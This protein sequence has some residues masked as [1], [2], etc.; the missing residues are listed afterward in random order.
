[1]TL[2]LTWFPMWLRPTCEVLLI[3]ELA[4]GSERKY[5]L[6]DGP[7]AASTV[8]L[9]RRTSARHRVEEVFQE[10]KGELGVDHFE[11][12]S[13]HGWQHHMS[14]VQIAHWFFVREQCCLGTT[15]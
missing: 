12:R 8:G 11:V 1:M 5:W 4:D 6:T 2:P 13:W 10:C 9:V 3:T 14:L 7:T 15:V